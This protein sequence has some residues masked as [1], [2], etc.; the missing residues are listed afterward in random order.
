MLY[1]YSLSSILLAIM[2][3]LTAQDIPWHNHET[4]NYNHIHDPTVIRD[5]RGVY[6]MMSTNNMLAIVQ[7][8]DLINWTTVDHIFD[9]L[10]DWGTQM[11]EE[12]EDI[13]APEIMYMNERYWVYYSI[14]SFGSNNSGIGVASSPT[15][16]VE[17]PEYEWTH[18]DVVIQSAGQNY[19]AIDPDMVQDA[20]GDWW[21]VFGSFWSGIRMV[22][23]DPNT[24]LRTDPNNTVHLIASRGGGAI[25]GASLEYKDGYYY[26]FTSWDSCCDGVNSTYRTMIGRSEN[27]T[28]PYVDK[29][30]GSLLDGN[31]TEL[32]SSYDRYIGPAGG[33]VFSDGRKTYLAHHYYNGDQNGFPRVHFRE[34]VWDDEGWPILTQP[35][36]GRRQA[37]E[38]E[39]A[40]LTNV[41][42]TDG[43]N[44]SDGS[45][46]AYINEPDS[47]VI[48]H[49]NALQ[50]GVYTLRIRYTAGGGDASHFLMVNGEEVEIQY[51]GT[52]QW[53]QFP[54]GQAVTT[55]VTLEEGYNSLAFRPGAGFAELDRIDLLR[56]ASM[57]LEAGSH[58][59][60][61]G[62]SYIAENNNALLSP[63][64]TAM[65]EYLDF[66]GESFEALSITAGGDCDGA[67]EIRI[68]EDGPQ[69]QAD[70]TL[71]AG[72]T[73][74]VALPDAFTELDNIHDLHYTYSG[75]EACELDQ[76]QFMT[77]QDC[78]GDP[79]GSAYID[80]C[81]NCVEGNTGEEPCVVTAVQ[82]EENGNQLQAWPNPTRDV[83]Y[84]SQDV[85]WTLFSMNGT[86]VS[87][88]EGSEV[89]LTDQRAGAYLLFPENTT[90]PL[91]IIKQR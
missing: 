80:E 20:D 69:V 66:E 17:S 72:E 45:Y 10:P 21:M 1:K 9:D 82:E 5:D 22:Q 68:G 53:G 30:G 18:H 58:D 7:S 71:S 51:P 28:G 48:F 34:V 59:H 73:Y 76:F 32:L 42:F 4:Y 35:F 56:P 86:Q 47:R 61:T 78:H 15:L 81:G 49:I 26:L 77:D 46:V 27:I 90:S 16:D 54:E 83:I 13:W 55:S 29:E 25:E 85:K 75:S 6:T 89:N 62:V 36:I 33:A 39:H 8:D 64:S 14:S 31:A 63:G 12:A 57:I 11:N 37:F 44:A 87:Q 91:K 43:Q 50:A 40:E 23:I 67:F 52:P 24:G 79:G 60:G 70:V 3:N 41:E 38:A 74:T 84:L 19:N 2:F 88:G 65:Y